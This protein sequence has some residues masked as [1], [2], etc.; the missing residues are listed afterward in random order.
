MTQLMNDPQKLALLEKRIA[1]A[2]FYLK[3]KIYNNWPRKKRTLCVNN[4]DSKFL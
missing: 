2:T 4:D 3:L 1:C